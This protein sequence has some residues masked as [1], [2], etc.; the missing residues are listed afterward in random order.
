MTTTIGLQ[1]TIVP[2]DTTTQQ[3]VMGQVRALIEDHITHQPRSLQKRIGP[4]EIGDPCD[5][6]LAAKLAGWDKHEPGVAWLPFIGTCVHAYLEHLF[7][8]INTEE[9]NRGRGPVFWCEQKVTVGQIGGVDISGSTDLYMPTQYDT[10][11]TGMTVDWKIVGTSTLNKV[12]S[13]ASPGP[14]YEAQAHL[15]AK[16]WNEAGHKTSHVCVYFMPRNAMTLADGYIWID[17]YRPD[18]AKAA[19]ERANRLAT[20]LAAL[21]TI[22]L[23]ARDAWISGLPRV[24][25]CWDCQKYADWHKNP[26]GTTNLTAL[27]GTN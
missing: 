22:S 15:Y 3:E 16:G 27:L 5:H 12:R 24:K 17:Q 7:T 1:P 10:A 21:E 2:P 23:E 6:C 8:T 19:L 25:G 26:D 13:S 9:E 4:S 20:N 18:I 11:T 14:K